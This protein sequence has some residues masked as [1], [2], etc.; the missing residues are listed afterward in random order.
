MRVP[1]AFAA[2]VIIWST[3][4][5]A[6]QWSSEGQGFLFGVLGRMALGALLCLIIARVMDI[7]LPW[8]KKARQAYLAAAVGVYGAMLS[9][10]WGAQF[11]PSGVVSVL[12]G[13]TPI[14]TGILAAIWLEER[15][16]TTTRVI[17]LMLAIAGLVVVFGAS[18]SLGEQ[19]LYGLC[20]VL[21]SVFL[22]ATSTVW[23]KQINADLSPV[24]VTT[25]ALLIA[26]PLYLITWAIFDGSAPT[27]LTTRAFSAIVYLGVFGSALGF[28]LFFYLLK[29]MEA[30]RASLLTLI[31]PV[32]AL[33][34]GRALND[35]QVGLEVWLG[36]GMI[37]VGLMSH[38][39]GELI[40]KRASQRRKASE[41][42]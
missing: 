42:A 1:A 2:V 14:I 23:V 9:V 30:S 17:G 35:E 39:W 26:T 34:L 33:L 32:L 37:L 13:L 20:A 11:I 41:T 22:H 27:A 29:Q 38:E 6:I 8:H 31:T 40:I 5:L 3:T 12:F 21:L 4:P 36:T 25:G 15:S 28:M 10:Y 7:A 16:L 24:A 19:A 18:F